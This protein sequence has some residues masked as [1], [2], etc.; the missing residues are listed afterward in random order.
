MENEYDDFCDRHQNLLFSTIKEKKNQKPISGQM[1][2]LTKV[3]HQILLVVGLHKQTELKKG[4]YQ[5]SKQEPIQEQ[6][7]NNVSNFHFSQLCLGFQDDLNQNVPMPFLNLISLKCDLNFAP[8]EN[9][10]KR[11]LVY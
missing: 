11:T 1:R 2:V 10:K 6:V 3:I 4:K 8:K 9:K 7:A 5:A